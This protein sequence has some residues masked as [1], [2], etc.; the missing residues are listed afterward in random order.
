VK[1]LVPVIAVV[2]AL[3][4]LPAIIVPASASQIVAGLGLAD[5]ADPAPP[6]ALQSYPVAGGVGV[7]WS[8]PGSSQPDGYVVERQDA[9]GSWA[10]RSG[11]LDAQLT[12]WVDTGAQPGTTAEYRVAALYG[13]QRFGSGAIS[14]ARPASDPSAGDISALVINAHR[15]DGT[16]W[17]TNEVAAPVSASP[18][19]GGLRTLTAGTITVK[20]PAVLSGPGDYTLS[21][22]EFQLAQGDRSCSPGKTILKVSELLY[23]QDLELQAIAASFRTSDCAGIRFDGMGDIRLNSTKPYA[24]VF[25]EPDAI[26]VGEVRIGTTSDRHQIKVR[27]VGLQS[28][29]LERYYLDQTSA[30]SWAI[31][32]NDCPAALPAGSSCALGVTYKPTVTGPE[33]SSLVIGDSTW[34]G[35]NTIALAGIGTSLPRPP[36]L[37]IRTT[38]TGHAITWP[39]WPTDGGTKVRGYFLYRYRNDQVSSQ[40]VYPQAG[41]TTTVVESKPVAG[42]QYAISVVNDVGEG[43][44]SPRVSPGPAMDQIALVTTWTETSRFTK[45][46]VRG[47]TVTGATVVPFPDEETSD[48]PPAVAVAASPDGRSLAFVTR[49]SEDSLWTRRVTPG[50]AGSAVRLWTGNQPISQPAWS[51]DGSRIAFV[52]SETTDGTTMPCVYVIAAS[53]GEPEKVDCKVSSPSWLPDGRSLVVID[54]R[55]GLD[56]LNAIEAAPGGRFL[57]SFRVEAM[58]GSPVQ[59][60][61][62]GDFIAFT[63]A[64]VHTVSTIYPNVVY[65]SV[66]F[67]S[68][69]KAISWRPDSRQL[70]VLTAGRL[71]LVDAISGGDVSQKAPRVLRILPSGETVD[72]VWQGLN[73]TVGTTPDMVGPHV[74]IPFDTSA[75]PPG[76][77]TTC[78]LMTTFTCQSPYTE[79]LPSG[80][81]L[82]RVTSDD[83]YGHQTVASRMFT[84][85]ATGP[86]THV[87]SPTYGAT[88]AGTATVRFNGTDVSGV[89]SYDVRYRKAPFNNIFGPYTQAWSG[90]H[91]TSV[92]L[93]LTPGYEYCVSARA[94]DTFGN[95]GAWSAERCFSRPMDDRSLTAATASWTRA[96]W[97]AFYLG[98]ATH[99]T[100]Y[101]ASLTRTVQ[102]KRFYMLA[103]K[104]PTCGAAAVYLDGRYITTVSLYDATTQRQVLIALPAQ[105]TMFSGT[106]KITSRSAS[107]L[108]QID[109]LAVRRT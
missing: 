41:D 101:G 34:Q 45:P 96:T 25:V 22:S 35:W 70:L 7:T 23:T 33:T 51:S 49:G 37:T 92:D 16:T 32:S 104:C 89:S 56:Y 86:A 13:D 62:A 57:K 5:T 44:Q 60:S 36:D 24:A 64:G 69:I 15:G 80:T 55:D 83:G 30:G 87:V 40:W 59:V 68:A 18:A 50:E 2:T 43:P 98:T 21:G 88:T 12:H 90:V 48:L 38:F 6:T 67:D 1:R 102:G 99:T 26:D 19:D 78:A 94:K 53:G 76:R 79:T 9:T 29:D 10:D 109:G 105:A 103:T 27:N 8:A 74:S 28:V 82:L 11:V 75:L 4:A 39:N 54:N 72:A 20:I 73:L 106:L 47:A 61:P 65:S 66:D 77:S 63:S 71:T 85:D 108:V 46:T 81:H 52:V 31:E 93:A 14:V 42:T 3:A 17:L 84:V 97:S 95:V 58:A 91:S 107:K 100:T